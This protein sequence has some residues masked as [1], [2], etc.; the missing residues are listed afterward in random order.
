MCTRQINT[1]CYQLVLCIYLYRVFN[2]PSTDL[3]YYNNII[4]RVVMN[5]MY[6]LRTSWCDNDFDMRIRVLSSL[7][8]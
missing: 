4:V 7:Y 8:M 1:K 6:A 2:A 5:Y 3:L